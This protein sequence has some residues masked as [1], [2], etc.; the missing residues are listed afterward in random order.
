MDE[1]DQ[2]PQPTRKRRELFLFLFI[3]VV[4]FPILSVMVVGTYGLGVWIYQIL[5]GPPGA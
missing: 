2:L 1:P 3:V 4:L 5:M